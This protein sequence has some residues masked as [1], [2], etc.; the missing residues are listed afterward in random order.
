MMSSCVSLIVW[1]SFCFRAFSFIMVVLR[2]LSSPSV[3][4]F[5]LAYWVRLMYWA[6]SFCLSCFA[7]VVFPVHGV[8]VIR[9]TRFIW[10]CCWV[11]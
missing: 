4:L 3:R 2:S 5:S 1:V 6:F 9:M 7:V 10:D 11:W 8:P